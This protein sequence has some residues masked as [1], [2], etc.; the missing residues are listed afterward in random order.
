MDDDFL[1]DGGDQP[2]PKAFTDRAYHEAGLTWN[3]EVT[4]ER[5]VASSKATDNVRQKLKADG[6]RSLDDLAEQDML[7]HTRPVPD[8]AI[9][10]TLGDL[11]GARP[12]SKT[13]PVGLKSLTV[14]QE[15]ISLAEVEI[16]LK[17]EI[18]RVK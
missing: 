8:P 15:T 5:L 6:P 18:N 14:F 2:L 9:P 7:P 12:L 16:V 4:Q 3:P 13:P 10:I 1:D 17:I 11:A